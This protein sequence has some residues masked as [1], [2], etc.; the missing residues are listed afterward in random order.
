MV[1][2][3]P[4][5]LL[6]RLYEKHGSVGSFPPR[7][8]WVEAAREAACLLLAQPTPGLLP[9]NPTGHLV[10]SVNV[11]GFRCVPQ[12]ESILHLAFPHDAVASFLTFLHYECLYHAWG[13]LSMEDILGSA[14]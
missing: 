13:L 2:L 10:R 6:V 4:P 5:A 7:R 1:S 3:M 14:P 11:V 12:A 8:S 9:F